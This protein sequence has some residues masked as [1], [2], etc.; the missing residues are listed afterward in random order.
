MRN[1]GRRHGG[2]EKE[3][4]CGSEEGAEGEMHILEC[5]VW[6]LGVKRVRECIRRR[7]VDD[8]EELRERGD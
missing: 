4:M 3:Q 5:C 7:G 1:V 6:N 8:V 2:R